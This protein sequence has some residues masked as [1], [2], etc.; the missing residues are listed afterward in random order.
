[1]RAAKALEGRDDVLSTSVFLVHPYLDQPDMG[2]GALI[3]TDNDMEGA[4]SLANQ[5]AEQY[6]E[7]R[8]DLEPDIHAPSEAITKA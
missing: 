4:V 8:F 5:L 6:W 1:M 7:R 2:S 3:I